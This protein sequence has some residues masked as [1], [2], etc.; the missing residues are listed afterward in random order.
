MCGTVYFNSLSYH[1]GT[2]KLKLRRKQMGW[3]EAGFS[4]LVRQLQIRVNQSF[5]SE[6]LRLTGSLHVY[7][8]AIL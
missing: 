1:E 6:I 5:R 8:I 3:S 2:I 7:N 4:T